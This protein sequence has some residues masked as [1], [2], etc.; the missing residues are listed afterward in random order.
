[1]RRYVLCPS[2]THI[3]AFPSCVMNHGSRQLAQPAFLLRSNLL[4]NN[5]VGIK[6]SHKMSKSVTCIRDLLKI[7]CNGTG[8]SLTGSC[9]FFRSLIHGIVPSFVVA[10]VI[11]VVPFRAV[12]IRSYRGPVGIDKLFARKQKGKPTLLSVAKREAHDQ[13]DPAFGLSQSDV[14]A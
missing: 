4:S 13:P 2:V 1:M 8:C 12:C 5:I 11:L 14:I 7:S 6:A 9:S 10:V 3:P